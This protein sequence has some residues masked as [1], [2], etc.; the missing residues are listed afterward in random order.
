MKSFKQVIIEAAAPRAEVLLTGRFQG[1]HKGH[2]ENVMHAHALAQKHNASLHILGT[3]THDTNKNPLSPGQKIK[4]L[5]RAFGHLSNTHISVSTPEHPTLLHHAVHAYNRGVRHLIMAGGGDRAAEYKKLLNSYNGV[6]GKAHGYYKFDKITV[7]NTG[8]RKEGISGTEQRAHAK[9]GSYEK[10]KNNLPQHIA[11]NE[12]HALELYHETR[13]HMG[14]KEDIDRENYKSGRVLKLGC[15][16]EDAFTGLKGRVVYR[17]PTY[18]TVQL[19]EEVS[20][21]RWIK[22]VDVIAEAEMT[23]PAMHNFRLFL[24]MQDPVHAQGARDDESGAQI[25]LQNK[26]ALAGIDPKVDPRITQN[27]A[28]TMRKIR[29][30]RKMED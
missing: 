23:A 2:E 27:H 25:A 19:T 22:D 15:L 26:L 8:A 17:G 29:N 14:L 5:K 20:A 9:L 12:N 1:L 11:R 13:K 10:F 30:F 18:V 28:A 24:A 7:A 21:K 16:V 6:R 4:H 3:H